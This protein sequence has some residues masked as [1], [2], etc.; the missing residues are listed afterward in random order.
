[1]PELFVNAMPEQTG[2]DESQSKPA[3]K[4]N[5]EARIYPIKPEKVYLYGTCL[6]D[7]LQPEAGLDA[8]KLLEREGVEV[9]FQ[10][11]RPAVVSLPTPRVTTMKPEAL[12]E[13]RW[14]SCPMTFP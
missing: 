3:L 10:T 9:I 5:H 6:V 4:E 1:M 11:S 12:P 13:C 2:S 7:L 14:R 8:L